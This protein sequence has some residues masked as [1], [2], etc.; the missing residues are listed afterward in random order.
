[1]G[2]ITLLL[3]YPFVRVIF[4]AAKSIGLI[5]WCMQIYKILSFNFKIERIFITTT[6]LYIFPL[7]T[8]WN[9]RE[10]EIMFNPFIK[11]CLYCKGL[12]WPLPDQQMNWHSRI[13]PVPNFLYY[14]YHACPLPFTWL[15]VGVLRPTTTMCPWVNVAW[16]PL[17]FLPT[18]YSAHV[19]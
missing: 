19:V 9:E 2:T 1:M 7:L 8:E 4:M 10:E 13:W 14:T 12:A 11:T 5:Y 3:G 6:H 15:I 17:C 16:L 18:V